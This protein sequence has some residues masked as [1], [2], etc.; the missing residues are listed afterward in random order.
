MPEWTDASP[1]DILAAALTK[2]SAGTAAGSD[3]TAP[4]ARTVVLNRVGV[5][6]DAH[7]SP[8]QFTFIL[9][10]KQLVRVCL[11]PNQFALDEPVQVIDRCVTAFCDEP[12]ARREQCLE[13]RRVI[14]VP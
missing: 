3:R 4:D 8:S 5:K 12:V 6:R 10:H 13:R 11:T 9:A 7:S 2:S 14:D 1:R